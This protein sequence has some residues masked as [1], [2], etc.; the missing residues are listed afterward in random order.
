MMNNI[1]QVYA[2]TNK[3]YSPLRYPGGKAGLSKFL[4][5]IIDYNK[6]HNCIY[7]EPFAG[8]AG[9]ALTLLFLEKVNE[10][11]I[12]DL[13]ISIYSFWNSILKH[14]SE[15]IQRLINTE[16]TI[17]EWYKQKE[18][19][20]DKKSSEF[21]L[22][23]A[24]FFLNRTNRS[25]IINARPIGGLNQKSIWKINARFNKEN[26]IKRIKK[27]SMYK[28]RIHLFNL[29]GIELMK[30]YFKIP[31]AFFYID[32]PYFV[33]GNSLYLNYFNYDNHKILADFLNNNPNF[34]WILTYDNV[35]QIRKFYNLR[36]MYFFNL[37]YHINSPK[38]GQEILVFSETVS[39][40]SNFAPNTGFNA[41]ASTR[42]MNR[43]TQVS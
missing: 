36:K 10:I 5:D 4:F 7:I 24:T 6:F 17:D 40:P 14:S 1:L 38:E 15:F 18:I 23:F 13:D 37:N 16:I 29:D 28:D 30:N 33:K 25:G 9:S 35:E 21:D 8:G 19:Y 32:P 26:L 2:R 34:N 20:L 39:L 42:A 31:N 12:N 43:Q 22:G 41:D 3:F 27:I 11:V